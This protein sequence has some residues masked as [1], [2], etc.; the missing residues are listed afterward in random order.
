MQFVHLFGLF[1]TSNEHIEHAHKSLILINGHTTVAGDVNQRININDIYFQ[2]ITIS[3]V[4][5]HTENS[6]KHIY[7]LSNGFI[8][9]LLLF[10]RLILP[11]SFS[12]VCLLFLFFRLHALQ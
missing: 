11:F 8:Y 4:T 12:C 10:D 6:L 7:K 1:D 3:T 5:L 2:N 9:L